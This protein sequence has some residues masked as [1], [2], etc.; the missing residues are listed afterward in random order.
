MINK[1][2]VSKGNSIIQLSSVC[3]LNTWNEETLSK[4]WKMLEAGD[5]VHFGCT[6]VGHTRAMMTENE[7]IHLAQERYGDKLT[8]VEIDGWEYCKLKEV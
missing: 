8:V 2:I 5:Y 1:R 4:A 6:A 7:G 3:V